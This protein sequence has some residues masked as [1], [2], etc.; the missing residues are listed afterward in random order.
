MNTI[1]FKTPTKPG[2]VSE[3]EREE[4]KGKKFTYVYGEGWSVCSRK[5]DND[6]ELEDITKIQKD[7]LYRKIKYPKEQFVYEIRG[8]DVIS[9]RLES[10]LKKTGKVDLNESQLVKEKIGSILRSKRNVFEDSLAHLEESVIHHSQDLNESKMIFGDLPM[11]ETLLFNDVVEF[12]NFSPRRVDA[13]DLSYVLTRANG[14]TKTFRL[15]ESESAIVESVKIE[16]LALKSENIEIAAQIT[17]IKGVVESMK[18][19]IDTWVN[20]TERRMEK[21]E[22]ASFDLESEAGGD[23]INVA[24]DLNSK[25]EINK[26]GIALVEIKVNSAKIDLENRYKDCVSMLKKTQDGLSTVRQLFEKS[27]KDLE[28]S[29]LEKYGRLEGTMDSLRV[30]KEAVESIVA[31]KLNDLAID[32]DILKLGMEQSKKLLEEQGVDL[33]QQRGRSKSANQR[34]NNNKKCYNCGKMGH[35][36]RDCWFNNNKNNNNNKN[37]NRKNQN[38]GSGQNSKRSSKRGSKEKNRGNEG[39]ERVEMVSIKVPKGKATEIKSLLN[40][41]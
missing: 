41:R 6:K 35:F 15:S 30:N 24:R 33:K 21:L 22:T 9:E 38:N 2:V 11:N 28:G 5:T 37:Y 13:S 14:D 10:Y 26:N 29:I 39:G 7:V 32:T 20:K 1:T 40:F 17:S 27:K 36:A 25:L 31:N 3:Q 18:E 23:M 12:Q 34:T 4:T 16:L 8:N 19:A